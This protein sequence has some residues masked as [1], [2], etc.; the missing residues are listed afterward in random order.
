MFRIQFFTP[1]ISN[2]EGQLAAGGELVLGSERLVFVV[3][4]SHWTVGDYQQQWCEGTRRILHGETSTALMTQY[5]GP[6]GQ[7]HHMWALW[8]DE[9]HIY[10]QQHSVVGEALDQR[11]DP[12]APYEHVGR[13]I[14]SSRYALPIPEWRI[15]LLDVYAAAMGIRWPLYRL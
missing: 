6:D 5:D 10:V 11:F 14:E 13:R 3:G 4:L 8:R 2:A 15:D 9:E 7:A 1:P 12:T